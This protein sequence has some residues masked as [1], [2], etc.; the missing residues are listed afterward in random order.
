MT[1]VPKG[2]P[3]KTL[4]GLKDIR[5]IAS[6]SDYSKIFEHFL[7]GYMLEDISDKLCKQQYGGKKV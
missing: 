7:L 6:T 5:K 3:S 4:K 1:P 2:K